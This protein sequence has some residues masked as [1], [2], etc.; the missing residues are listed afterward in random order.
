MSSGKI[1]KALAVALITWSIGC[2]AW[3]ISQRIGYVFALEWMEGGMLQ[4]VDQ[5]RQGRDLYGPPSVD[6]TPFPYPPLFPWLASWLPGESWSFVGPRL[7]AFA[8]Y[9]GVGGC[10]WF[11]ARRSGNRPLYAAMGVAVWAGGFA[12]GGGWYD[13]ARADGLALFLHLAGVCL[14]W[15]ERGGKRIVLAGV[16]FLLAGLAKQVGWPLGVLCA[17]AYTWQEKPGAR[18]LW[19]TL[20]IGGIT[21]N[22]AIPSLFGEWAHF[23]IFDVLAGHPVGVSWAVWSSALAGVALGLLLALWVLVRAFGG[24]SSLHKQAPM[25]AA[26]LLG[27]LLVYVM[28]SI[29]AGA[30][31]NVRLPLLLAAAFGVAFAGTI[32]GEL[33]GPWKAMESA[34]LGLCVVQLAMLIYDPRPWTPSDEY[35][36]RNQTLE[37]HIAQDKG[38]VF[39]PGHGYLLERNRK[40][41]SFHWMA[42][43]DL[44][45]TGE[46]EWG[47]ALVEGV[48]RRF[49]QGHYRWAV[50]DRPTGEGASQ[51]DVSGWMD[52]FFSNIEP[53]RG[54]TEGE[55]R[56]EGRDGRSP[57]APPSGAPWR[58]LPRRTQPILSSGMDTL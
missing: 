52:G 32:V 48:E 35:T 4:H 16:L 7:L 20:V 53:L 55:R 45:A 38:P 21:L 40:S 56:S 19:A 25:I 18:Q 13:V 1:L 30:Y 8:G 36:A 41:S 33:G 37:Q 28:G 50:P 10:L 57:A 15:G 9:V 46:G 22:W 34:V 49:G 11:L 12:F 6:F 5:V 14:L 27:W 47:R 51:M 42:L 3:V 2:L 29:H 17:I 39:A 31:D 24:G 54:G 44:S 26:L 43:F 23:Y 58:P